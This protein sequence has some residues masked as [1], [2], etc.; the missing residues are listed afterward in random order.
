MPPELPLKARLRHWIASERIQHVIVALIIVN[1]VTLGLE[2]SSAAMEA[3]GG[4]LK[5]IDHAL[6]SVF[7]AEIL[8]KLYAF[9]GR[10]F[11]N[12]WNV[13]DFL[14]VGV[15]LLP[16]T[17]PLTVLRV[18]RVLRLVS[19]VP[20]FR[21]VV[22]SLLRAVPGILSIAGLLLIVFYVAAVMAT[23]FFGQVFP[24]WF[25]TI[26]ES[27]YSLFQIMTLESWSMGIVRPVMEDYPHAWLFFVPF[28]IVTSFA[29]LNLFIALIV[30]SMQT[31]HEQDCSEAAAAE[32]LA[33]DER[34]RLMASVEALRG[35]VRQLRALLE[36]K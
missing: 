34:E 18:L 7:V 5:I 2:T 30:N 31:V 26:G 6:L 27:M 1:A 23:G 10:F 25:G 20:R 14:V 9:G 32:E 28:V 21:F 16:A 12:P 24:H 29:V 4:L 3:A 36:A 11:R 19:M 17:G 22:E 15:A 13:F 8:V 33:H 35:D